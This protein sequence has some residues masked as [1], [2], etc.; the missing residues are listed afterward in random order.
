MRYGA[1]MRVM[2]K[3]VFISAYGWQAV[4]FLGIAVVRKDRTTGEKKDMVLI[5]HVVVSF[6]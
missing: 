6:C 4:R 3:R 1:R 5:L 2:R